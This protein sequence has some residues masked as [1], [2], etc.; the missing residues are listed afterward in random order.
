MALLQITV[1]WAHFLASILLAALFLFELVIVA[2]LARKLPENI[3]LLFLSHNRMNHRLGWWTWSVA[4]IS[5][6]AWLL[7]ITASMSGEDLIACISSDA[8]GTVLFSTQF[9]HLWLMCLISGIVFGIGLWLLE[10]TSRPRRVLTVSVVWISS[11]QLVSLA[12]GGHAVAN[13]GPYGSVHLL[14]DALHLLTSAFWPG[15]LLPLAMFLFVLLK[16][17]QID[18]LGLAAAVVRRFSASSLIAVA[19]MALTGLLNSVF[20]VGNPRVLLTTDYGH[21]LISKLVLFLL[22]VGFGALNLFLVKPSLAGDLPDMNVADQKSAIRSLLRN[23]LC[24]VGLGAA[25]ILIVAALGITPP[26]LH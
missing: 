21:L 22:M 18:A 25:V 4:Q 17:N 8:L 9:G 6:I 24:E 2:S 19:A 11:I 14:S 16:S 1:R 12:W 20:M 13:P 10:R 23:V 3:Q 15:A 7:L 26:P 5:W